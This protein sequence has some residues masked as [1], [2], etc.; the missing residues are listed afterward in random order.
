[1]YRFISFFHTCKMSGSIL[2]TYMKS[3]DVCTGSGVCIWLAVICSMLGSA[4]PTH[5]VVT[6]V[7]NAKSPLPKIQMTPV[8]YAVKHRCL[9]KDVTWGLSVSCVKPTSVQCEKGGGKINVISN[10]PSFIFPHLHFHFLWFSLAVCF[11]QSPLPPQFSFSNP[12]FAS[13]CLFIAFPSSLCPATPTMW[14][15]WWPLCH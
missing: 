4:D 5:S 13:L 12:S 3:L 10:C 6:T 15:E 1:M 7:L 9:A 2:S 11:P 8:N 14:C